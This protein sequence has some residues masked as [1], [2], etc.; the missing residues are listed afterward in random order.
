M[1]VRV[2]A[3]SF[4]GVRSPVD[5]LWETV[6]AEA[7]LEPGA[8]PPVSARHDERALFLM[9]GT[10]E[11]GGQA[12]DAG[13]LLVLKPGMHVDVRAVTPAALVVLGG[14]PMDGPRHIWWNFVSSSKAR[15][16]QA[17]ADWMAG[18]FV[19]VPGESDPIPAP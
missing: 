9:G 18:R 17:R 2:V 8:R 10:V 6:L 3:G 5:F 19:P 15:I 11:I 1:R 16:E 7:V 4:L 14:E 13:P 12:F